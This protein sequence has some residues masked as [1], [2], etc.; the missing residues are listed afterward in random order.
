MWVYF[1]ASHYVS[2]IN[3]HL[4]D[5]A[6]LFLSLGLYSILWDQVLHYLHQCSFCLRFLAYLY[7]FLS[8]W[9]LGLFPLILWS[10]LEIWWRMYWIFRWFLSI[11]SFS[12]YCLWESRRTADL[13]NVKD[14][15]SFL[16]SVSYCFYCRGLNLLG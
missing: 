12:Q 3:V 1:C 11:Q 6:M 2:Q 7:L 10:S 5:S 9:A 16:Y 14:L 8:L 13:F 15:L 4:C